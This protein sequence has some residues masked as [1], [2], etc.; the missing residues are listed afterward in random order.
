MCVCREENFTLDRTTG[1]CVP[2]DSEDSDG[3]DSDSD[4]EDS[5]GSDSD[6]DSEDD[7]G[8]CC[9]A[10]TAECEACKA[11]VSVRKY[12]KKNPD[13]DGCPEPE[14]AEDPKEWKSYVRASTSGEAEADS[15]GKRRGHV[16]A[17]SSESVRARKKRGQRYSVHALSDTNSTVTAKGENA[18]GKASASA[19]ANVDDWWRSQADSKSETSAEVTIKDGE[20]DGK[21]SEHLDANSNG[22]Y[23][24]GEAKGKADA[25]GYGYIWKKNNVGPTPPEDKWKKPH[26]KWGRRRPSHK[27]WRKW[28]HKKNE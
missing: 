13:T 2:T 9:Q 12:C 8:V 21:V 17:E 5:N 6:S 15:R 7:P 24:W 22:K 23:A 18:K 1:S 28:G 14:E 16:V 20:V 3:S 26:K 19:K 27:K 10:L 4:S 11:G 25:K